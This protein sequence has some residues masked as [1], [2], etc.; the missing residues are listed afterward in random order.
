MPK[1]MDKTEA[2]RRIYAAV[3]ASLVTKNVGPDIP[4][5]VEEAIA[6]EEVA[7]GKM[8]EAELIQCVAHSVL[9]TRYLQNKRV[10]K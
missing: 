1:L 5:Q 9:P 3:E 10:E 7:V 8:N 4:H 6:L 2:T